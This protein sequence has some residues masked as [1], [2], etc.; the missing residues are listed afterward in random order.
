LL[1]DAAPF[2][3]AG[4][5]T[6]QLPNTI[7]LSA[8]GYEGFATSDGMETA[9]DERTMSGKRELVVGTSNLLQN[10][11]MAPSKTAMDTDEGM[12]AEG[13]GGEGYMMAMLSSVGT[14]YKA[15]TPQASWKRIVEL[16]PERIGHHEAM[17]HFGLNLDDGNAFEFAQNMDTNMAD[18]VFALNPEP[19]FEAGTDIK[20]IEGWELSEVE[21]MDMNGKMVKVE[22]LLKIFDL[23]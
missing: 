17:D 15:E 12:Y 20:N 23:K 7:Y 4:L 3:A 9:G 14:G 5:K 1:F 10:P 21:T 18:I 13:S 2:I 11:D 16:A 19:F 22:K 6:E 8:S